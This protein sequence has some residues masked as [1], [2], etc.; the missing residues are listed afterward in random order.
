MAA[1]DLTSGIGS[2]RDAWVF[3][4]SSRLATIG[5]IEAILDFASNSIIIILMKFRIA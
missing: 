2:V 4:G 3:A 5:L 1:V